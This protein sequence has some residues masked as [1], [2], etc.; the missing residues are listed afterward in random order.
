MA[1]QFP[2]DFSLLEVNLYT[3]SESQKI[4]I[5]PLV[6]EINLYE[7]ILSS[8]LQS[9]VTIQDIGENLISSLPILGQE[10]IEIYISSDGFYYRLNF[11]IYNIDGRVMQENM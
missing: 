10:R 6:L 3:S 9:T 11:N 5:K 4:D 1:N 7:S 2:G 8:A